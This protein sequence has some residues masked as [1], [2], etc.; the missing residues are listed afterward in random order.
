MPSPL[1]SVCRPLSPATGQRSLHGKKCIIQSAYVTPPAPLPI[2][3][4]RF[5]SHGNS[6][7]NIVFP[8][9]KCIR[10][11]LIYG[12]R[13]ARDIGFFCGTGIIP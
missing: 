9:G 8:I 12:A 4:I 11:I 10:A 7:L 5:G 1:P 2:R 6:T 3:T 13:P